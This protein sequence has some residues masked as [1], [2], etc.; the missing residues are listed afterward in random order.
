MARIQKRARSDG[1]RTYVVKW[2]TPDGRDHSRGGFS[3]KRGAEAFSTSVDFSAGRGQPYNPHSGAVL[4]RTAAREWLVARHD[5]K[6]S[7]R[8]GYEALLRPRT[9]RTPT[10][11]LSIDAV[12]GSYPIDRI[13]RPVISTW[14][15]ALVRSG[16]RPSTVRHA[17][18]LVR[19]VLAQAVADGKLSSSPADHVR[20]PRTDSAAGGTAG[21]VDDEAQFLT[22]AQVGSL[23]AAAPW[24]YSVLV[25]L[26]AW[27]GLRAAEL[28]G[29]QI[30]DVEL[31]RTSARPAGVRVE[32]TVT[33]VGGAVAYDTPKT[34]GS[35]R[36]VPLTAA[37]ESCLRSYLAVHPRSDEPFAPLFPACALVPAKPTGRRA[38]DE[39]GNRT[40]P[41]AAE[42]LSRLPVAEAE[43]GLV[44]DWSR[45][46]RHG[47]FYSAVYRPT[48]LRAARATPGV[49]LPV[50]LRFHALRHTYAS[51]CVAAGIEPLAL[52]KFM[53]HAKV[54]TTLSIYAHLFESDHTD[55]MAALGRLAD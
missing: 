41:L 22:A 28:G 24:P 52:A 31:A 40:A 19:M 10:F 51:L 8:Q 18:S 11:G 29:L 33:F 37:T 2:R 13:T 50:G 20:L 55:A 34:R 47:T 32:R 9:A 25:H 7:T 36:R 26:A 48:V 16:A 42:A 23:T 46:L 39:D 45:P 6:D 4:F 27:A 21:V 12:L 49:G 3:T 43:S 14:V 53:G 44:L 15:D 54:T 30:R 5:L 38:Y 35:K 17:F 1:S